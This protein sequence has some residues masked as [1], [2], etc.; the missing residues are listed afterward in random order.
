MY[1]A[2][3]CSRHSIAEGL[4]QGND[5]SMTFNVLVYDLAKRIDMTELATLAL[6]NFKQLT[7]EKFN[8]QDFI[9]AAR[10]VYTGR[11]TKEL[12]DFVLDFSVRHAQRLYKLQPAG[13]KSFKEVAEATS[14]GSELAYRLATTVT[15]HQDIVAPV[16]YQCT[17]CSGRFAVHQSDHNN[18]SCFNCKSCFSAEQWAQMVV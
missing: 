17:N 7:N 8:R 5:D 13:M 10:F 12:R 6:H 3:Y 1:T 11:H 9:A 4:D 15:I 18:W 14:L 16:I 2:N